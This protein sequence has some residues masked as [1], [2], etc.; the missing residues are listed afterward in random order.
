MA[1]SYHHERA[2]DDGPSPFPLH[3]IDMLA[4]VRR[5]AGGTISAPRTIRERRAECGSVTDR[6]QDL[7][8]CFAGQL[9]SELVLLATLKMD[10]RGKGRK[11]DD[12]KIKRVSP[13]PSL[14][15]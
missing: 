15:S 11:E 13:L 10:W 14:R 7:R 9:Q 6:L 4:A 2:P 12:G 8:R 1:A 3:E 5:Q